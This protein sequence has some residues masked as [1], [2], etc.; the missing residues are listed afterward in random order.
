[1]PDLTPALQEVLNLF[2]EKR[3]WRNVQIAER[4]QISYNAAYHR[5]RTLRKLGLLESGMNWCVSQTDS[6]Q[7]AWKDRDGHYRS[8]C[9]L[10]LSPNPDEPD[11][12]WPWFVNKK[13]RNGGTDDTD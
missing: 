5:T 2:D 1:M 7:F 3:T 10:W 8:W 4:L 6:G 13:Y 12:F 9:E 11:T